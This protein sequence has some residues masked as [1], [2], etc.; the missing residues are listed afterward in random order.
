MAIVVLD[1]SSPILLAA[2]PP[3]FQR[4]KYGG[5]LIKNPSSTAIRSLEDHIHTQRLRAIV[6]MLWVKCIS[7]IDTHLVPTSPLLTS[8][9]STK[10]FFAPLPPAA[11]IV[12]L[13]S[14]IEALGKIPPL[15]PASAAVLN[16]DTRRLYEINPP[17]TATTFALPTPNTRELPTAPLHSRYWR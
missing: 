3:A 10:A 1:I 2:S 17:P 6:S 9:S 15:P 13:A 7:A 14:K 4:T 8:R 5:P 11:V 12:D 16:L